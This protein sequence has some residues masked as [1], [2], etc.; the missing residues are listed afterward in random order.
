MREY[1]KSGSVEGVMGNHQF[2]LRLAL[3]VGSVSISVN[4]ITSLD[5]L[6]SPFGDDPSLR[7]RVYETWRHLAPER[8]YPQNGAEIEKVLA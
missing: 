1:R 5:N 6:V 4:T 8:E 2:L 7:T 3:P